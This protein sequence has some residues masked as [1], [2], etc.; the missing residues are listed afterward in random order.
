M[1]SPRF[2]LVRLGSLGDVIHA[3]PAAAALRVRY[4]HAQIDWLVDPRYVPVVQL[5][6]GLDDVIAIDPRRAGGSLFGTIGK[7]RR[8][9]YDAVVDLQG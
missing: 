2:L 9:A 3:I 1:K 6:E 7:L 8:M 4:P 5:V